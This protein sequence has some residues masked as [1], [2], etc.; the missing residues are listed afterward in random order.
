M[1]PKR[2]LLKIDCITLCSKKVVNVSNCHRCHRN[3]PLSVHDFIARPWR[4]RIQ[5][6]LLMQ[7]RNICPLPAVSI[8]KVGTI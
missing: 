4:H 7:P 6:M 5:V 1:L 3:T 8:R 2:S